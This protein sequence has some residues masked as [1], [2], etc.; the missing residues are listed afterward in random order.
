MMTMVNHPGRMMR[1]SFTRIKNVN[2]QMCAF[3]IVLRAHKIAK[4]IRLIHVFVKLHV[5]LQ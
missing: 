3:V 5:S 2:A 4:G 1:V